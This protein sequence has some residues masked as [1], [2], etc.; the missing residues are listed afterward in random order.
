RLLARFPRIAARAPRVQEL[1]RRW[2]VLAIILVRFAYG[3]RM[4]G[5]IV[6]GTCGIPLWRVPLFNFIGVLIWA[7]LV[8]GLGYLAGHAVERWIGRLPHPGIVLPIALVFVVA[9]AW[10][11]LQRRRDAR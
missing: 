6:I 5:P 2:D 9:G 10:L 4:A 8:A 1:L 11:M 7:P 3:V